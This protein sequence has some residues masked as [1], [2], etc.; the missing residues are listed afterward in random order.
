MAHEVLALAVLNL[1]KLHEQG[2]DLATVMGVVLP[3]QVVS[4]LAVL[5]RWRGRGEETH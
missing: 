2:Q 1:N 3:S 5:E 4:S